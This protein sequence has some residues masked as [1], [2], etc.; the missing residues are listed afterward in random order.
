MGEAPRNGSGEPPARFGPTT[1]RRLIAGGAAVGA[2]GLAGCLGGRDGP[3]PAPEVTS[4]RIEDWRRID[5]SERT[6][7]EQSY[8]PVTVRALERTRIF[9]YAPVADAL[10]ETVDVSGSPVVFFATRIDLRPAIDGLPAGI[11]R[12]RV[13][14]EVET[15]AVD[16]FRAQLRNA[17]IEDVQVAN[18][19]ITTV[20]SGHTATAWR[21][22]GEYAIDGAIPLPNGTTA[23]IDRRLEIGAR[24][25]VWHDGT[26]VLVAGGAYPTES[27]I[28]ILDA[29]LPDFVDAETA[30]RE[31]AGAETAEALATDPETF[32][33]EVSQLLISVV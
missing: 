23:E 28:E 30:I 27:L 32:D 7:F 21:L 8:G 15:A 9:E 19:G 25:G 17:G 6:A 18:E 31:I 14:S 2:G 11:G 3:V 12:D 26:D 29:A 1:R 13:M 24:L 22:T 4:D 10:A 5:E 16:A 20:R 33:V